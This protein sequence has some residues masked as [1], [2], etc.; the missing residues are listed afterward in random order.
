MA[1]S[2]LGKKSGF[3]HSFAKNLKKS[4][5]VIVAIWLKGDQI[6]PKFDNDKAANGYRRM[7]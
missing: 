7:L 5:S 2:I 4:V 1:A 3:I 6:L